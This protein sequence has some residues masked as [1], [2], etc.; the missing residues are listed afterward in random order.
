MR[1][2]QVNA[3]D[4]SA[5]VASGKWRPSMTMFDGALADATVLMTTGSTPELEASWKFVE[6]VCK[7]DF[8][9]LDVPLSVAVFSG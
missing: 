7:G 9:T 1:C 5:F 8:F 3:S 4:A 2:A 6:K